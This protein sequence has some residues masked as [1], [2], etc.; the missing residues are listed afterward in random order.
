MFMAMSLPIKSYSQH[1]ISF[2]DGWSI[3]GFVGSSNFHGDLTDKTNSFLNNT[4]FSKYF[5][6]DR[7]M[8]GGIYVTKMF[9]QVM[10]VRGILMYSDM[11]S[12]KESDKIYFTG[13]IF[14]YSLAAYSNLTNLFLGYSRRRSWDVYAFMGLG[15]TETRSTAF[16]MTTGAVV[17]STGYKKSK[18]G[19]SFLRMTEIVVPVGLGATY[20]FSK[21]ASVFVEFTRH[22][23]YTNKLDAYPVEGT[24][25]ESLGMMNIGLSYNFGLPTHWGTH[26]NPRY[27]GK[28]PDPAIRAFNKRKRVVMKTKANKKA[29][30]RRKRYGR[31]RFRR[32]RW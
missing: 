6:Q 5:Y 4:P 30:K 1:Y 11:K 25:I 26:R 27:N 16:N 24:K 22:F 3:S 32:H 13:N 29:L 12:T 8:G 21:K 17:G 9:G 31:K 14:E 28:S 23:V 20:K 15:Y 10:G 7:K 19:N 2:G 18:S